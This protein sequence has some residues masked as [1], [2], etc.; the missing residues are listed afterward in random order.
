MEGSYGRKDFG[1]RERE[2]ALFVGRGCSCV[3]RVSLLDWL[4]AFLVTRTCRS[5]FF[6]E[7]ELYF[8]DRLLVAAPALT[9]SRDLQLLAIR[10]LELAKEAATS[11]SSSA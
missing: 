7:D 10:G 5:D 3:S 6:F 4:E 2:L 9:K 11:L 1:W 8:Y